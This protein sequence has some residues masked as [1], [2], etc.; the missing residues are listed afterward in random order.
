MPY[1]PDF[2]NDRLR[3]AEYDGGGESGFALPDCPP[4]EA[5]CAGRDYCLGARCEYWCIASCPL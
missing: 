3:E 4:E 5:P 2:D 1:N